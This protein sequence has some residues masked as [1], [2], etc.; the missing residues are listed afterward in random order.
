V[1]QLVVLFNL[2]PGV[3]PETFERFAVEEDTPAMLAL[4]SVKAKRFHR[5]AGLYGSDGPAPYAY[6]ELL[7]V[8]LDRL[9]SDLANAPGAAD[10]V[11]RF[12]AMTSDLVFLIADSLEAN[13][14]K[15]GQT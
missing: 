4:P 7:D 14:P 11:A 13:A 6:V 1:T 9:G 2:K 15:G 8:D 10:L 5:V 3:A 12:R